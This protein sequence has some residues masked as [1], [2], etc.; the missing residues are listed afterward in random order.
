MIVKYKKILL[1]VNQVL[2]TLFLILYYFLINIILWC[3]IYLLTMYTH[4]INIWMSIIYKS[5][6]KYI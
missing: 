5:W 6:I 2:K 3:A 1:T 4:S